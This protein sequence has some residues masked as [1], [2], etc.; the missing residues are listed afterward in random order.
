MNL[1]MTLEDK[2]MQLEVSKQTNRT[3]GT[4][5]RELEQSAKEKPETKNK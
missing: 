1:T 4:R 5:I 2:E 3:L